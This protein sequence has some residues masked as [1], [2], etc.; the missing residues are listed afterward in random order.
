MESKCGVMNVRQLFIDLVRLETEL[1]DAVDQRLRTEFDLPLGKF[2]VMQAIARIESCRVYDIARELSI[3]VGAASKGVDRVEATGH[4]V[5]RPNPDDRRS[6]IVELT[7]VGESLLAEATVV[8]DAELD[9]R[10][11]AALPRQ[12]LERLGATIAAL[13][14][15]GARVDAARR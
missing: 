2:D 1:W 9:I 15:A 5:R 7:P 14:T 8:V 12:E 6:S 3:T 10:L 13:R 11:G 4:C